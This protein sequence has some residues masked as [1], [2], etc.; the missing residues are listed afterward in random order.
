VL[1]TLALLYAPSALATPF[2]YTVNSN[3]DEPDQLNNGI[4]DIGDGHCTLRA[5]IQ[6]ANA[7]SGFSDTIDFAPG[8]T[9]QILLTSALPPI[10]DDVTIDGPGAGQLAIDGANT[11]RVLETQSPLTATISGLTIRHGLAPVSAGGAVAGGILAAGN[12][13]LDRV[14]V[15]DNSATVNGA[16]GEAVEAVGAGVTSDAGTLTLTHSTVANNQATATSSG[17]GEAVV[18]G[19]GMELDANQTLLIDHSTISGN[20]ATATINSGTGSSFTS[21][22]GGG[23]YLNGTAT[24]TASTIS[25]N[26]AVGTGGTAAGISDTASG[27]GIYL[28]GANQLSATGVTLSG[29][30]VSASGANPFTQAANVSSGGSAVFEDTIIANPISSPSATSCAGSFLSH[31]YNLEDDVG[32]SCIFDQTTDIVGQDPMLA[33][34]ADNGGP[35]LTQKLLQGSP[36]IDKGNGVGATTDQRGAGFPRISDSPTITNASGGDGSDIGAYERDSVPPHN[37]LISAS[38][39]KSPANNNNPKLRG[40]AEAGSIVRL[41][42]TAGCTGPAVKAGSAATFSSPGLAVNVPDNST[43]TFHATATDASNNKSACSPGFTYVEDSTPPNTSIDSLKVGHVYNAAT[44]SFSSNEAGSTF[45][46]KIDAQPYAPCTSPKKWAGLAAGQH[47]IRVYATDKAGNFDS[48][49]AK[50]SFT[51]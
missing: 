21:P 33:P 14:V 23:M 31:G 4:C 24:L 26:Q 12:V 30:S 36:A 25:G 10:S 16:S 8:V 6:E 15:T 7:N 47:T 17:T 29:N 27:G 22:S 48:T 18:N 42:K 35:T 39:P 19:G 44:V 9:G 50:Q 32:E 20:S 46:C 3:G 1:A 13:T 28:N 41:Y 11:Y 45:R 37:P 43:T 5:A 40:L 49:P 51:M 2:T 34:L 38:T